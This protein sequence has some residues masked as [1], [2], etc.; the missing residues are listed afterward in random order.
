MV[1]LMNRPLFKFLAKKYRRQN[2]PIHQPVK[3]SGSPASTRGDFSVFSASLAYREWCSLTSWSETNDGSRSDWRRR[4]KISPPDATL[5]LAHKTQ[6]GFLWPALVQ[7]PTIKKQLV[8]EL[9]HVEPNLSS[10]YLLASH[11][12][13][14]GYMVGLN[15]AQPGQTDLMQS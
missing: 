10:Q 2:K 4:V 5:L 8:I 12:Y 6:L 14:H 9:I 1:Y 13:T 7:M 15:I 11:L 3:K